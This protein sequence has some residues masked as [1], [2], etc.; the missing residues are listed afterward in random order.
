MRPLLEGLRGVHETQYMCERTKA[1]N[2]SRRDYTDAS[3]TK[4]NPELLGQPSPP[5][6]TCDNFS[7]FPGVNVYFLPPYGPSCSP[8]SSLNMVSYS[9]W[10]LRIFFFICNFRCLSSLSYRPK[11]THHFG[12]FKRSRDFMLH[13]Y[14]PSRTIRFDIDRRRA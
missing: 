11:D 6:N 8:P 3:V 4:A 10:S 5:P 1:L 7:G 2:P 12:N 14:K 9:S 13:A